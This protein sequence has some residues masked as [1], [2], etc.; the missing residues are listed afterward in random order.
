M[1]LTKPRTEHA[2]A[3]TSRRRFLRE[4][5]GMAVAAF[6]F[7]LVG[8]LV[9]NIFFGPLAVVLALIALWRGTERPGR[10]WAGLGLGIADLLVLGL[11]MAADN[12][13]AWSVGG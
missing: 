8:L 2:P 12:G 3:G 7:G 5:D 11:V 6:V 4:A 13:A 9:F 10:A 1:T